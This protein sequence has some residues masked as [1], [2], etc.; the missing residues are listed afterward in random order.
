MTNR[1][2]IAAIFLA[3]STIIAVLGVVNGEPVVLSTAALVAAG[4][5]I[6]LTRR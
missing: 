4:S 3:L 1:R 5:G 2:A 6:E